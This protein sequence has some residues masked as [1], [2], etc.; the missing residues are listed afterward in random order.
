[1]NSQ[2]QMWR[3]VR[4]ASAGGRDRTALALLALLWTRHIY[5][6]FIAGYLV[7]AGTLGDR[8]GR[9]RV[10]LTGAGAFAG[11]SMPFEPGRR[12]ELVVAHS[13]PPGSGVVRT[14]YTLAA[15]FVQRINYAS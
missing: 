1:M 7:T 2:D 11:L 12:S 6:F 9:R 10:L 4:T 8:F 13:E 3:D 15:R 14:R 5:Q